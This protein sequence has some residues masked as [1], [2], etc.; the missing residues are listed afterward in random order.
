MDPATFHQFK[1]EEIQKALAKNAH[2]IRGL[3]T[4]YIGVI[5]WIVQQPKP[6]PQESGMTKANNIMSPLTSLCQSLT[7]FSL[8]SRY[9]RLV[10]EDPANPRPIVTSA[11]LRPY[12]TFGTAPAPTANFRMLGGAWPSIR[13]LMD[14]EE[15]DMVIHLIKS[16]PHLQS[17]FM[18]PLFHKMEKFLSSLSAAY[19]PNLQDIVIHPFYMPQQTPANV[20]SVPTHTAKR[21]LEDFAETIQSIYIGFPVDRRLITYTDSEPCG[22]HLR[23]EHLEIRMDLSGMEEYMLLELLK[24]CSKNLQTIY[25]QQS[26]HLTNNRLYQEVV[27][28]GHSKELNLGYLNQS[29]DHVIASI[30]SRSH[31][32]K[33]IDM[34]NSQC[35]DL[36]VEAIASHCQ[37]LE[38]LYIDDNA[39]RVSSPMFHR[40]LCSATKLLHLHANDDCSEG[41]PQTSQLQALDVVSSPWVCWS[42]KTF[43]ADIAGVPRPDVKF[44]HDGQPVQG[45]LHAGTVE[46]SRDLQ[47]RVMGQLGTL[48]ELEE[49]G[50]G[51]FAIDTG[52]EATWE[53]DEEVGG[54]RYVDYRFQLTCLEMSLASG[55]DLLAGLKKLR[56]LDVTRMAHRIGP[57]ELEWMQAN[58]QSL[59]KVKGLFNDFY[60]ALVPGVCDWLFEHRPKWGQEYL[61]K[62]FRYNDVRTRG[63]FWLGE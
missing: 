26:V 32:W 47:R 8:G 20:P 30:V 17:I 2:H 42:L 57:I 49:L 16:N 33:V 13:T 53:D 5:K 27:R 50:L 46:E 29:P 14:D 10:V 24:S 48:T 39:P 12:D 11:S 62:D 4:C 45:A 18:D 61:Q 7:Q 28:F 21:F 31:S 60:P 9:S 36:T 55:L 25:L 41:S 38:T 40:I 6:D 58:L 1:S 3:E 37:E 15:E 22:N 44:Q 43:K 52:N 56:I 34:R 63:G 19:L 51:A 59:E 35:G 54:S 23:L